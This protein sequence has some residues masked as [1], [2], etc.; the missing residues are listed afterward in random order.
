MADFVMGAYRAHP[1]PC[2]DA[3]CKNWLVAPG[4]DL[5][6][7]SFTEA[8]AKAVVRLLDGMDRPEMAAVPRTYDHAAWAVEAARDLLSKFSREASIDTANYR[9]CGFISAAA[10]LASDDDD[11]AR[12]IG[13]LM[14]PPRGNVR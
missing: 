7:V 11:V 13:A 5:Q 9:L 4:A 12:R 1:C 10:R 3:V 6:G 14:E 8:Q 2:G